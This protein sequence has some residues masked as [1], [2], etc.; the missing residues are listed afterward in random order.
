MWRE[1]FASPVASVGETDAVSA[2]DRTLPHDPTPDVEATIT[3]SRSDG[4]ALVEAFGPEGMDSQ[5]LVFERSD[6]TTVRLRTDRSQWMAD[7]QLPDW[8]SSFDLDIVM[9][10]I[11]GRTRWER[12]SDAPLP[13]QLPPGVEWRRAVPDA[14]DWAASTPDATTLLA[15][16]QRERANQLFS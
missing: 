8:D 13:R 2:A 16:L 14:L 10:A 15:R 1:E 11:T 3:W 12:V 5:L 9:D 7:L 4:F 6:R